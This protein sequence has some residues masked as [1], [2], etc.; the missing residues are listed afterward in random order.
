MGKYDRL[1]HVKEK[2]NKE[3]PVLSSPTLTY[4]NTP[5]QAR[6]IPR[7]DRIW[8]CLRAVNGFVRT[9]AGFSIDGINCR[10]MFPLLICS[11]V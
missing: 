4:H 1:V 2:E 9:S 11:F 7:I 8:R 3:M 6:R 10:S 5:P